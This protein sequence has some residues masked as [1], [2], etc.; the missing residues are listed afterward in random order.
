MKK[1]IMAMVVF[2]LL[3]TAIVSA[4]AGTYTYTACQGN[5]IKNWD[6]EGGKKDF[7]TDYSYVDPSNKGSWTMGPEQTY[8]VSTNPHDYHS[9][10]KSFGDHT[11]GTGNM[12]I[13]NAACVAG[14]SYCIGQ[15]ALNQR[16]WS[17]TVTVEPYT[18]YTFSYWV[19]LSYSATGA[20]PTQPPKLQTSINGMELGTYDAQAIVNAFPPEASNGSAGN[21][22]QVKYDWFSGDYDTAEITII[23]KH[24]WQYGD[25]FALDDIELC[26]VYFKDETGWAAGDRYV[27]KGNWATYVGYEEGE[28]KRVILY[29]GRTM[30]AGT[31]AFAP[32]DGDVRVT[33]TLNSG[34][35][36]KDAPENVKIQDYASAP[37]GNPSPG[38][39]AWKGNATGTSF[40]IDVPENKFYGVH[41]DLVH[42]VPCT[43]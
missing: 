42:E 20:Y 41:V 19:A 23:D 28:S 26:C 32:H 14:S 15:K 27:A 16:I 8:T 7:D 30:D 1:I 33:I 35:R 9:G 10:W 5:L 17:Q 29:A 3:F 24:A 2:A 43:P 11:T 21:W 39:F 25:D 38:L 37:S 34:W 6:F 12:M 4:R 31:V 36:F 18:N 40:S 13:V 22:V